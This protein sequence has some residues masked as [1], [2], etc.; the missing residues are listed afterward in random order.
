M[1]LKAEQLWDLVHSQGWKLLVE[2][3][4]SQKSLQDR[5]LHRAIENKDLNGAISHEAS[6]KNIEWV[7]ELPHQMIKEFGKSGDNTQNMEV[8]NGRIE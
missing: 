5:A 6:Y 3:L 2:R 4:Q 7:I 1:E 8:N